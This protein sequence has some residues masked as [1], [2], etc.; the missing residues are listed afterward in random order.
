NWRDYVVELEFELDSGAMTFYTHAEVMDTKR[1]P[2]FSI[3]KEKCDVNN[4][5]YGK[6]MSAVIR[7]IGGRFD[8]AID[9][10]D[11]RRNEAIRI[12]YARKGPVAIAIKDGTRL[13]ITKLQV[14]QLR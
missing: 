8:V 5:E 1:A 4:V 13:T 10:V 9:G 14:R 3:G 6:T 11:V 7:V 12:N 2:G